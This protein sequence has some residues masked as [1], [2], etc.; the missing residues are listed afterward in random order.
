MSKIVARYDYT[1]L[2]GE[3]RLQ[4]VRFDPKQ[5]MWLSW[6]G[7]RQ[8][9]VRGIADNRIEWS[10][11]A[12]YRLPELVLAL[13][14]NEPTWIT[15]GEKDAD[16]LVSIG[17]TA[18]STGGGAD[19]CEP[20]QAAWFSR[21]G[22]TSPIYVVC[23]N[24]LPGAYSGHLRYTMLLQAG[25]DPER[26]RVVA[27]KWDSRRLKDAHDAVAACGTRR[28]RWRRVALPSLRATAIRYMTTSIAAYTGLK[29][30]S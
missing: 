28:V 24:D 2:A 29:E 9:W 13:K 14:A 18:T 22:S 23:D 10:L 6:D 15:E 25:V 20:G 3:P 19:Q 11:R 27:P 1:S 26:I 30:A 8:T 21:Y 16:A 7:T 4:K 5:F 17:L 12:L